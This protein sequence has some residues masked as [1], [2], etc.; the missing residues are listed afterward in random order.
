MKLTF[1]IASVS[2]YYGT[3]SGIQVKSYCCLNLLGSSVLNFERLHILQDSIKHPTK[4]IML[5][6]LA[7][8][9]I[10]NF[11]RPDILWDSIE[12]PTKMLSSF[13]FDRIFHF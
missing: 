4:K 9:F 13:E 8:T 5:F 10:F 7:R 3:Q 11:E 1:S 2:I 6:E 12:H